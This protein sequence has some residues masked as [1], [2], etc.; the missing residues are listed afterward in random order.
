M[1]KYLVVGASSGIGEALANLLISDGHHVYAT[2]HQHVRQSNHAQ[3]TYAHLNV[4]EDES[5]WDFLPA[6]LDGLVY[7]PGAINLKPFNR[8]KPE[9]FVDDFRLQVVGAVKVIQK[10]LPLLKNSELA[11]IVLFSTVAVGSGY[12]YHS[13]VSASKGSIE[14]LNHALAAELAPKIRV[15]CIAP[16]LTDTPLA[17]RLLNTE[18]KKLANEQRHPL[19]KIGSPEQIAEM[20]AFLLSE[21]SSWITGQVMRVDGGISSLKV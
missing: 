19:R 8:I 12:P 17:A 7:C 11:S 3:L 4:L 18:E 2:Y 10:V 13:L 20:A 5:N 15:N 6:D 21:K 16:S 14:G 9:D 1:K